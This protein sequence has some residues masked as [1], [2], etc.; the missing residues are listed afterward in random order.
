MDKSI[1]MLE[2]LFL[3]SGS[4]HFKYNNHYYGYLY[5]MHLKIKQNHQFEGNFHSKITKNLQG[6]GYE[7]SWAILTN[8]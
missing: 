6:F 8:W 7:N 4:S 2:Y 3:L 1:L 5:P